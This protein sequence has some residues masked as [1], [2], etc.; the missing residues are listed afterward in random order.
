MSKRYMSN[1]DQGFWVGIFSLGLVCTIAPALGIFTMI[2]KG[3]LIGMGVFI[4]SVPFLSVLGLV[5]SGWYLQTF[6]H[7]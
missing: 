1:Q 3:F 5:V 6:Y 7:S 2:F 4:L